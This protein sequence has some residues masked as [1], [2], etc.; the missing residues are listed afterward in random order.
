MKE[1][2]LT[3]GQVARVDNKDFSEL[4]KHKW[5][6]VW[7]ETTQSFYAS[8]YSPGRVGG[9]GNVQ[10]H[11]V[12]MRARRGQEVDHINRNTLDNQRSNL[13]FCTRTQNNANKR[14]KRNKIDAPL[15]KGV[16][17][18]GSGWQAVCGPRPGRYLGTFRTQHAAALAYNY[19][20]RVHYGEFAR[21]NEIPQ[22][23]AA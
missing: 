16:F 5:Y 17:R 18:N 4:S 15:Y 2:P 23:E 13:R 9:A 6:A 11:R 3:R 14:V 19:A 22:Q 1:I 20:A 21:L 8:R 12:I 7:C 10:M